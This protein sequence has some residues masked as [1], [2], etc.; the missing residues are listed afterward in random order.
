MSEEHIEPEVVSEPEP[1][2]E[3]EPEV[4]ELKTIIDRHFQCCHF[5]LYDHWKHTIADSVADANELIRDLM[6]DD[7]MLKYDVESNYQPIFQAIKH[8]AIESCKSI[9][10]LKQLI[11]EHHS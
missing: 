7:D 2:P 11:I 1:E 10:D 6:E 4:V 8:K 3:P 9:D 5:L